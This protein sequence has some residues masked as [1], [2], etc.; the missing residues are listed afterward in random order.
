MF[1]FQLE[2]RPIAGW[3]GEVEGLARMGG[4]YE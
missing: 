2:L 4:Y 3:G 1:D